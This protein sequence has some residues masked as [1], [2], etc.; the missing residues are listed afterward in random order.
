MT[1]PD[2]PALSSRRQL[3]MAGAAA[4]AAPALL[5]G[6]PAQ[7]AARAAD[8]AA[9]AA[10]DPLLTPL[11][12]VSDTS[13]DRDGEARLLGRWPAGLR[14]RFYRN[15]PAL[16]E[17]AGQ[18]YHH[19]FDGDGMVQQYRIGDGRVVHRGRLVHTT[20]LRQEREAG[21]FIV[22]TLGTG[23]PGQPPASGPDS[24]NTANTNAIEHTGRVLAL[25]EGGSAYAL[26]ADDLA[27]TGPVTWRNDLAQVPFSA[28]PKVDARGHLW[29]IGSAGRKLVAWHIDPAGALAQ[30][31]LTDSPFPGGMVHDMAV[32]ARH[33]VV[34]LPPLRMD[35]MAPTE[36]GRRRFAMTPGEPLPILVMR[37]DD[38][39]QQRVFE[40][41][42]QMVFHIGNAHE[43]ADGQIMLSYVG[44]PDAWFLDQ[45]AVAMM[46][47]RPNDGGRSD[48]FMA[49]LDM[50]TGR[51]Q[52][53]RLPGSDGGVEFPR[54]HPAR[55]GM[56]SRQLAFGAAW[57]DGARRAIGL[58]HGVQLLDTDSGRV[59]RYDYGAHQIVEE[60][61]FVPKPGGRGE[62]DAWLL[63]T[64]FDARRQAT[65]LNL[66]DAAHIEDGPLAQA[67]LPYWLPLGFHGNFTG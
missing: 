16:Y 12:G 61:V 3:L 49:R 15:G 58:F 22:N 67:V 65:V 57:G 30:V 19:W 1:T 66:L 9:A 4:A 23:F 36:G 56:A 34:P 29:N 64:T 54:M 42:P 47:G 5:L 55:V 2:G 41:P 44:A 24:F 13:G 53:Q 21:R 18:R 17:R 51:A 62:L 40:L 37:K 63:G 25:W 59:R 8:F 46:A 38:L 20:K 26:R 7:A 32:T 52:L 48:A 28:H 43:T 6:S 33:L 60:H 11:L 45:G 10:K 50:A 35:F 31:Q 14:G 27:T 39:A